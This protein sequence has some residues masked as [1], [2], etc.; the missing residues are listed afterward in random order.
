MVYVR[1]LIVVAG[2]SCAGKSHFIED[3]KANRFPG[4]AKQLEIATP[5]MWQHKELG[6]F[7]PPPESSINR[8]ILHCAFWLFGPAYQEVDGLEVLRHSDQITFVTLW[9]HPD[10]LLQRLKIRRTR[11]L[12]GF[13]KATDFRTRM[14]RLK[15]LRLREQVYRNPSALFSHYRDWFNFCARYNA[16]AHWVVDVTRSKPVL[17]PLTEWKN[18]HG[19]PVFQPEA[20]T[21]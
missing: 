13:G 15:Q 12:L 17:F 3:I 16:R 8:L 10:S 18:Q 1:S 20:T 6:R 11:A 19:N 2:P 21:D 4:I 14:Q 9:V 5:S 7:R